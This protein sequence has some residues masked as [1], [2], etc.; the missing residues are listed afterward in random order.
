MRQNNEI[1]PLCAAYLVHSRP[2]SESSL[3]VELITESHGR[4]TAVAKGVKR[5]NNI[6]KSIL[7]LFRPLLVNWRG[8]GDLKTLV[9]IDSPTLSLPLN[10]TF[11]FSGFYLNELIIRLLTKEQ[12]QPQIYS[13]YHATLIA[14]SKELDIEESLRQFELTLINELGHGFSF[15]QDIDDQD[16]EP[17]CEYCLLVDQGFMAQVNG[18]YLGQSLI[19]IANRNYCDKMTK[20]QAKQLTRQALAP[21]L[22]NKPLHSR[23][24]FAR[25]KQPNEQRKVT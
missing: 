12:P 21:L 10:K 23:A 7:Q 20:Q 18:P 22:G 17:S 3:I 1:S 8:Q 9:R 11:L 13:A 25:K 2:F 5:K 24:L 16:I 19:N 15:L 4:I 14:L 6:N